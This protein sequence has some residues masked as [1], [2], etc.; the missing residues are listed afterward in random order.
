MDSEWIFP[1]MTG[2][3]L[4]GVNFDTNYWRVIADG[5]EERTGRRMHHPRPAIP[6]VPAYEGRRLYLL[7]HGAKTWLDEDG[8][9]RYA[10]E[11]RMGH[12]VPG[13][14]GVYSSA[15]AAMEEMISKKLQERWETLQDRL[16]QAEGT[17]VSHLFPIED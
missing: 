15:T 6:A 4:L 16:A 12:D 13:V 3:C 2:G 11:T 14:E 1:G 17:S 5:A 8:H 9:S 10:V 7:R